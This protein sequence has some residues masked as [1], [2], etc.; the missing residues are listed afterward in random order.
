MA[1]P[2][3][4]VLVLWGAWSVGWYMISQIAQDKFAQWREKSGAKGLTLV[5]AEE[6]W[7]GYPFRIEVGCK[8]F[9][10]KKKN[11]KS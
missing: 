7:G 2:L 6:T 3:I 8:G 11:K 9:S 1:V 4:T 10:L 5:C